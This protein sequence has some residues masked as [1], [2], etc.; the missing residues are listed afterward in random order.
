[1][2]RKDDEENDKYHHFEEKGDILKDTASVKS[3]KTSSTQASNSSKDMD[4]DAHEKVPMES[5]H[6][7]T[8]LPEFQDLSQNKDVEDSSLDIE[9]DSEGSK[10]SLGACLSQTVNDEGAQSSKHGPA[11]RESKESAQ[12]RDRHSVDSDHSG[13]PESGSNDKRRKVSKRVDQARTLRPGV[14]G[15]KRWRFRVISPQLRNEK[16]QERPLQQC[17]KRRT[18]WIAR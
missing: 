3:S 4:K 2:K 12:S 5:P 8:P 14:P 15:T 6:T 1:M 9:S 13:S 7:C 11:E 16:S 18:K 17:Q 10:K